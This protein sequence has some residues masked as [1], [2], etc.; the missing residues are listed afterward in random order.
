MLERFVELEL[1]I[2]QGE[3]FESTQKRAFYI[4]NTT[5]MKIFKSLKTTFYLAE[6]NDATAKLL[7]KAQA[8]GWFSH[9]DFEKFELCMSEV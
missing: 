5:R 1:F 2:N 9:R 3:L 4:F 8:S 6:Q 7:L